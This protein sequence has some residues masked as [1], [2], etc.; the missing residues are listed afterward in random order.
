MPTPEQLLEYLQ[1]A[2]DLFNGSS[3]R[4]GLLSPV[5]PNL[6]KGP[7]AS[8]MAIAHRLAVYLE[9][10]L[11]AFPQ[12]SEV[13]CVIDCEYNRHLSGGKRVYIAKQLA[14]IVTEANR[15]VRDDPDDAERCVFSVLPDIVLHRRRTDEQNLLVIELKKE[16]NPENRDYD[17][18]K[19]HAF[20]LPPHIGYGYILGATVVVPD[21][22]PSADRLLMRGRLFRGGNEWNPAKGDG[23]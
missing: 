7:A 18:F 12:I 15:T 16:S 17:H 23:Q 3:D 11:G 20:T 10:K 19:L 5:D 13:G 8:E 9:Q 6:Q 14:H 22:Q 1:A 4:E 21:K 2:I